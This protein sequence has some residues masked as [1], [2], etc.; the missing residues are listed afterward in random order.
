MRFIKEK[1]ADQAKS[2]SVLTSKKI[3]LEN[4]LMQCTERATSGGDFTTI[5]N[6]GRN[7]VFHRFLTA[8]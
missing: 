6:R 7:R 1:I 4:H 3:V 2:V 5:R 8:N